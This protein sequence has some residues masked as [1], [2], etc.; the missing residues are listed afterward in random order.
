MVKISLP[1]ALAVNI[2][3]TLETN[4][5]GFEIDEL[6]DEGH[7][8]CVRERIV[9][10]NTAAYAREGRHYDLG[11]RSKEVTAHTNYL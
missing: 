2:L 10:L 11:Y 4:E 1:E 7:S 9:T 3:S 6:S 5:I 8:A